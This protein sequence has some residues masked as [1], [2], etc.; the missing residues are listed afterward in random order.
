MT[1]KI[2]CL[3]FHLKPLIQNCKEKL[4]GKIAKILQCFTL[5]ENPERL[6]KVAQNPAFNNLSVLLKASMGCKDRAFNAALVDR[7]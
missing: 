7:N 6:L 1:S 3:S 2:S 4:Q 5:A